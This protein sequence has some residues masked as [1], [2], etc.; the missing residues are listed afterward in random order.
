MTAYWGPA[1]DAEI[2]YRHEQVRRQFAG[3]RRSRR[4]RSIEVDS[5]AAQSAPI[6]NTSAAPD[7]LPLIPTQRTADTERATT[8]GTGRR[9][10]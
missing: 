5:A 9:A 7:P 10:A 8:A 1:F 6:A 4:N 3:G 2:A